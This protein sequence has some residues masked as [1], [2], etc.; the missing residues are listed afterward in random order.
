MPSVT[1]KPFRVN[2]VML[3]VVAPMKSCNAIMPSSIP[4]P[5][6]NLGQIRPDLM[7]PLDYHLMGP[8]LSTKR[9]PNSATIRLPQLNSRWLPKNS[10]NLKGYPN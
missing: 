9:L 3:N 8:Y 5:F 10:P 7:A 6:F 4:S 2:D 1:T